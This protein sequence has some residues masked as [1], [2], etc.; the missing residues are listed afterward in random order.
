MSR[1]HPLGATGCAQI[2]ELYSQLKGRA[3]KR[4]VHGAK[5]AMAAN[6]GG[7]VGDAAHAKACRVRDALSGP[8]G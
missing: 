6:S 5:I 2:F 8:A 3:D 1:G 4:Q 7:W